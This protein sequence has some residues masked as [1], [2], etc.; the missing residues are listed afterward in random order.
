MQP[1]YRD[2][3]MKIC[4]QCNGP[5][6]NRGKRFCDNSCSAKW[7]LK[8]LVQV[9]Q[10]LEKGREKSSYTKERTC[11]Q[12]AAIRGKPNYK[13]RGANHPN[14]KGGIGR[15]LVVGEGTLREWRRCV[16]KR[17]NYTCQECGDTDKIHAHHIKHRDTHPELMLDVKNGK[18]LCHSCHSKHHAK[19]RPRLIKERIKT[20]KSM[21]RIWAGKSK[22]ERHTHALM[23][24]Q[25]RWSVSK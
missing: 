12:A 11:A 22:E 14:W 9:R 16:L 24:R 8:N 4:E 25:A 20:S 10:A 2:A 21:S 6:E 13:I 18:A 19:S 7:R 1:I 15:C 17:D 23:M 5:I 3:K